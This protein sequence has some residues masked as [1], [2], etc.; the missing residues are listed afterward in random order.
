MGVI[1]L[2]YATFVLKPIHSVLVRSLHE[3]LG[4]V[5]GV[6]DPR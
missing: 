2:F 1:I 4:E 3:N 5:H 6:M